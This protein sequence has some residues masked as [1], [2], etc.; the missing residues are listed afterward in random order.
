MPPDFRTAHPTAHTGHSPAF[1]SST[2]TA[3]EGLFLSAKTFQGRSPSLN[4]SVLLVLRAERSQTVGRTSF[5]LV[6]GG[7]S[8]PFLGWGIF[9]SLSSP[10]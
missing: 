3:R 4:R 10:F 6:P 9:L 7:N 1:L 5:I 8:V 2:Y